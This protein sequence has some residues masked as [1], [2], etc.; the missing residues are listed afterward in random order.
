[1]TN[2][3][4]LTGRVVVALIL[5]L[6][7]PV[8]AAE[9]SGL[10]F[11]GVSVSPGAFVHANVPL[12]ATEKSYASEGGNRAPAHA[13]ATL[14]VPPGFD[15]QKS[16]P[17]LV[18]FSTS[19]YARQNRDDIRAYRIEAATEGWLLLAGDG[20]SS[21]S[22]DTSGWRAAMTLA[23]LDALHRSFPGSNKWPIACVGMSGGAKRAGLLAPLLAVA[24]C[25]VAGIYLAGVNEDRLSDGY[26]QFKPGTDFLN[27]PV[28]ISSDQ[29][30]KIATPGQ[31]DHV[32]RS[33]ERTGFRRVRLGRFPQ[34]HTVKRPL[35]R[36]ALRWF[37]D[38]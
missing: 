21:P 33:I 13:V 7:F 9:K 2:H 15:P 10:K 8:T 31:T 18:V 35:T 5:S 28:F 17:V 11:A 23:A 22:R 32:K 3:S 24:G 30:D 36:T 16:W 27:T 4:L 6:V 37:R 34:G 14:V 19:D 26:R 20:P 1:M 12:S 29:N 25:R 38:S